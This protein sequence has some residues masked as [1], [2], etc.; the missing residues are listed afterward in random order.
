VEVS[1]TLFEALILIAPNVAVAAP[2]HS[3]NQYYFD[4]A[5]AR[6]TTVLTRSTSIWKMVAR[7]VCY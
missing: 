1:D 6:E 3:D 4:M 2:T 5:L 7:S